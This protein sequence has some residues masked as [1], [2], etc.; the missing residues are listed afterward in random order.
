MINPP[1]WQALRWINLASGLFCIGVAVVTDT[2]WM[3]LVEMGLG[4]AILGS[5]WSINHIIHQNKFIKLLNGLNEMQRET[6]QRRIETT[7]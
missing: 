1:S 5:V 6:L 2:R 3:A 7:Q 4:G